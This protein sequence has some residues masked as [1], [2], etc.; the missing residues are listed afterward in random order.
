[1]GGAGLRKGGGAFRRRGSLWEGRGYSEGAELREVGGAYR[2]G[3]GLRE[4]GGASELWAWL[5]GGLRLREVGGAYRRGVAPVRGRGF[6]KGAGPPRG[7][8][9]FGKGA[10][11][12]KWAGLIGGAGRR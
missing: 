5:Q 1:M 8:R 10:V 12:R 9:G 4:V 3:A 2:G 11:N 6:G 7:G